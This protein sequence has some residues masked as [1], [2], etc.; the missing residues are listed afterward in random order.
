MT[1]SATS[2]R[3]R[4]LVFIAAFKMLKALLLVLAGIG[5]FSLLSP[6][7]AAE[8]RQWLLQL[9]VGRGLRT[10]Q[11]A[12]TF[13]KFEKPAHI[14][15][16]GLGAILYGL[17][18]AAEGIGLWLAKRWAEYLTVVTTSLLVPFEVYEL[19]R[20][21]TVVRGGTLAINIAL[22]GYLVYRLRKPTR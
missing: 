11:S 9:T 1:T 17:L 6:R 19:S 16:F 4:G 7:V 20:R 22:V 13:L 14:E 5:A 18:F 12:L 8:T 2:R 21:V 15:E 10:V 3:D